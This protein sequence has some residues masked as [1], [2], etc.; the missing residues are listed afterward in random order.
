MGI[1]LVYSCIDV[2]VFGLW[3]C[4]GIYG[5]EMKYKGF[6]FRILF[7]YSVLL[8]L[9]FLFSVHIYSQQILT[10]NRSS[11]SNK[12]SWGL[13]VMYDQYFDAET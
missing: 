9:F 6:A 4:R 1:M 12:R 13:L 7:G 11:N 5:G 3:S 8:L 10:L 2:A